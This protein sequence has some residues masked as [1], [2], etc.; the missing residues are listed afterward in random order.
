MP[1]SASCLRPKLYHALN[2]VLGRKS[3]RS[4][5]S[6][7]AAHS[8]NVYSALL[9]ICSV[10]SQGIKNEGSRAK[11]PNI[12]SPTPRCTRATPAP[13]ARR[14]RTPAID[15]NYSKPRWRVLN[16]SLPRAETSNIQHPRSP[17][18]DLHLIAYT[19]HRVS[20]YSPINGTLLCEKHRVSQRGA[21]RR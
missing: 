15:T 16:S 17:T 10:I 7:L 21:R 14:P 19:S 13:T 6:F 8:A 3:F 4:R 12:Q 2:I 18:Y 9:Y 20:Q 5:V 1:L 11:P